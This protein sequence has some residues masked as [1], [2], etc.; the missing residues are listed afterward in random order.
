MNHEEESQ[1]SN[2]STGDTGRG[3]MPEGDTASNQKLAPKRALSRRDLI[4]AGIGG[5]AGVAT[6]AV[7][8]VVTT[9]VQERARASL[10]SDN[11]VVYPEAIYQMAGTWAFYSRVPI[12]LSTQ[13]DTD[14]GLHSERLVSYLVKNGCV[15]ASS[16]VVN[17]HLSRPGDSPAVVR[18]IEIINRGQ[19]PPID[20]VY[21]LHEGAGSS[22]N[23]VFAINLDEYNSR[24]V[25]FDLGGMWDPSSL[26]G[27]PSAF[28]T[29]T[30]SVGAHL[31]ESMTLVFFAF[32]HMHEFM[33]RLQYFVEGRDNSVDISLAGLPFRVTPHV[34]KPKQKYCVPWYDG[35]HKLVP[36]VE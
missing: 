15:C 23:A 8:T 2:D 6:G 28:S 10:A 9:Y 7:G 5:L 34:E 19:F 29:S 35:I 16:L 13:P 33:L 17:L 24:F 26:R 18:N 25:H 3:S 27:K 32:Q 22:D 30:F 21:Y 31:T 11:L 1:V 20:D 4:V 12:D 36:C 14:H